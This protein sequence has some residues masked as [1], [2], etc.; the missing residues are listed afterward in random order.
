MMH[1]IYS[2]YNNPD[3]RTDQENQKLLGLLQSV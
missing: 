1:E 2:E 3:M